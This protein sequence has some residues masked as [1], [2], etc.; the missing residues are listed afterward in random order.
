MHLRSLLIE[1][2]PWG[3]GQDPASIHAAIAAEWGGARVFMTRAATKRAWRREI[4]APRGAAE[5]VAAAIERG[6]RDAGATDAH[7]ERVLIGC[8]LTH[9]FI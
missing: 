7:V 5:H 8:A 2:G 3:M 1:S 4:R 6:I 9:L